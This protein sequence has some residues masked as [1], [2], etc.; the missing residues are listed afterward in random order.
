MNYFL[1]GLVIT[2]PFVLTWFVYLGYR[3]YQ[4]NAAMAKSVIVKLLVSIGLGLFAFNNILLTTDNI[5]W[6]LSGMAAMHYCR[7]LAYLVAEQLLGDRPYQEVFM[8]TIFVRTTAFVI[9]GLAFLYLSGDSFHSFM[10][11]DP[12]SP[13]WAHYASGFINYGIQTYLLGSLLLLFLKDLYH[14][15][16]LVYTTR[17]SVL[18][19]SACIGVSGTIASELNLVFSLFQNTSYRDQLNGISSIAGL[20]M[21]WLLVTAFL[22]PRSALIF[23]LR[24]LKQRL[25]QRQWEEYE[26]LDYLHKMLL[27]IVPGI[28]L[29]D[30]SSQ[31]LR[32]LIEISDA[33]QTIWSWIPHDASITPRIEAHYLSTL[34]AHRIVIYEPGKRQPPDIHT[35]NIVKYNMAVAKHLKLYYPT[36]NS[37]DEPY[38]LR[39][40]PAK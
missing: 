37:R 40:S 20:L 35:S 30:A 25:V 12:V 11:N 23:M 8:H 16:E 17:R 39:F 6:S 24:P 38:Q 18:L 34:L 5:W 21:V 4:D 2:I 7:L 26:L 10:T 13:N 29:R 36:I 33:R 1:V 15:R 14:H 19:L 32:I 3:L 31:S 22:I 9:P 28:H 27:T